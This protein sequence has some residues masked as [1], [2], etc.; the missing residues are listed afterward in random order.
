[1]WKLIVSVFRLVPI[2]RGV[3]RLLAAAGLLLILPGIN[4]ASGF[5]Y[6]SYRAADLDALA[7]PKPALGLGVDVV[8][9]QSVRLEITLVSQ[10]ASCPS[11]VAKWA[12]RT[13]GIAKDTVASTPVTQCIKVKSAKGRTYSIFIQDAL[14]DSLA[15]EVQPG[16]K[17]TLYASLVYSAQRGPGLVVNAFSAEQAAAGTADHSGVDLSAAT[18]KKK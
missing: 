7:A 18:R 9:A 15:K 2:L 6:D 3:G 12:M 10:A 16:A 17:L 8:P 4:P 5:D 11:K 13:A 1:M 14:A